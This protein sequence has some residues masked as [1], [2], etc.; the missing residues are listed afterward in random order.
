MTHPPIFIYHSDLYPNFPIC[1]NQRTNQI[2]SLRQL[3]NNNG[4]R[5]FSQSRALIPST[6]SVF[7]RAWKRF[8][9]PDPDCPIEICRPNHFSDLHE[10]LQQY[11]LYFHYEQ[12]PHQPRPTRVLSGITDLDVRYCIMI[13]SINAV[14]YLKNIVLSRTN[15][16]DKI[17]HIVPINNNR[18]EDIA[19]EHVS[20]GNRNACQ[21]VLYLSLY[22]YRELDYY[23][24]TIQIEDFWDRIIYISYQISPAMITLA[25]ANNFNGLNHLLMQAL[26]NRITQDHGELKEQIIEKLNSNPVSESVLGALYDLILEHQTRISL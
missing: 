20:I 17:D 26:Q 8:I 7:K 12:P 25:R 4:A 16:F 23:L 19:V 15:V 18:L 10:V 11:N 21:K 13:A 6:Y 22:I 14:F 9:F 1:S 3:S 5:V 2:T 24:R